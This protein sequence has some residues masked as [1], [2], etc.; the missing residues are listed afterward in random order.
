MEF[1]GNITCGRGDLVFADGSRACLFNPEEGEL[2]TPAEV[3]SS[4]MKTAVVRIFYLST[5]GFRIFLRD[6]VEQICNVLFYLDFT[7]GAISTCLGKCIIFDTK[8]C[9]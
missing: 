9:R 2:T 8:I 3:T 5:A 1:A 6:T 7:L 4:Y